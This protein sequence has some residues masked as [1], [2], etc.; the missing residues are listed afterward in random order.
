[1]Q[2]HSPKSTK[3]WLLY[4]YLML[5]SNPSFS[6]T[7]KP[8]PFVSSYSQPCLCGVIVS[9]QV[10]L[11]TCFPGYKI[12]DMTQLHNVTGT[13]T[14]PDKD[15]KKELSELSAII[16]L[17]PDNSSQKNWMSG[18]NGQAWTYCAQSWKI[19]LFKY[20]CVTLN[21]LLLQRNHTL[22]FRDVHIHVKIRSLSSL[23]GSRPRGMCTHL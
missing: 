18:N 21:S 19:P 10:W 7:S 23:A 12:Q 4:K 17:A 15:G 11:T 1:M 8:K 13:I 22:P 3:D 14:Q 2:K 5:A 20:S 6:L 9:E 16:R